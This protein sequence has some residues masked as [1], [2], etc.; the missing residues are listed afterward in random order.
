MRII[1]LG[2]PAAGKGTQAQMIQSRAGIPLIVMGDILRAAIQ[3]QDKTGQAVESYVKSGALVPDDL[4]LSIIMERFTQPDCQ[5]KGFLLDG[6]PRTIAQ[7]TAL[8]KAM[9]KNNTHIDRVLYYKIDD[10]VAIERICG[11]RVCRKC[12]AVYHIQNNPSKIANICD[13]CGGELWQR[14]DDKAEVMKIRLD[15]F[16][17]KTAPLVEYYQKKGILAYID[18]TR[19]IDQI[20][21]ES[22]TVLQLK[23]SC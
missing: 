16:H 23:P 2:P 13:L 7:A 14:D 6:F 15:A 12:D 17:K 20:F 8:E 5:N 4:I 18:A 11:R 10:A 9:E 22:L 3:R 21:Q 19:S 1:F